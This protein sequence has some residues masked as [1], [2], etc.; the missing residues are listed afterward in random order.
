MNL[1]L[2]ARVALGFTVLGGLLCLLFAGAMVFIAEDYEHVLVD[3][4]LR[5]QAE[6]YGL[7]LATDP[8]TTLPRTHRLSGYLRTPEGASDAPAE[9]A[10]LP[11]GIHEFE[12]EDDTG[13]HVGVFDIAPG[14][15]LLVIDLS[16]IERLERHFTNFLIAIILLGTLLSGGLGWWLAGSSIAPVRSLAKAVES[17]PTEARRTHL[18]V[19]TNADELGRLAQAIDGYQARLVEADA[20]ERAFFADAS[21]ELRTPVAVVRGAA[22]VLS[23]QDDLDEATRQRI[24][25]I[26]RGVGE[27]GELVD[28][29]LRLVRREPVE[30]IEVD[31]AR[32]LH[33]GAAPIVASVDGNGLLV[34]VEATGSIVVPL[35][36]ATLI[37]QGVVRRLI[38]PAPVGTL[39]MRC[40]DNAFQIT[41]ETTA[42][43]RG[44]P[45]RPGPTRSDRGLGL[46]LVGRLATRIGWQVEE[47]SSATGGRV[48]HIALPV[49]NPVPC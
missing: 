36:E 20:S 32:L 19:G 10:D 47:R 35:R 40:A 49:L 24:R 2:R 16:D 21:H 48:V 5:G 46:T 14:R 18:A 23:E 27:L 7:R 1:G 9:I 25:R 8:T 3:E 34:S 43:S 44:E 30:M 26:D 17:L 13:V 15:L 45:V 22:E 4:I 41:F 37:L 38:P 42:V 6:D 12:D 28:V 11:P 31:I 39:L 29:L 33:D